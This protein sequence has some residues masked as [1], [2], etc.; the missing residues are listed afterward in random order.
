MDL[1]LTL[2]PHPQGICPDIEQCGWSIPNWES[3]K[4]ET[5]WFCPESKTVLSGAEILRGA[6]RS[7]NGII[8][9]KYGIHPSGFQVKCLLI[10]AADRQDARES[11]YQD[12]YRNQPS[13]AIISV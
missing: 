6:W 13:N 3:V 8:N 12:G 5:D 1:N 9:K 11:D 2:T 10:S 7:L 4:R